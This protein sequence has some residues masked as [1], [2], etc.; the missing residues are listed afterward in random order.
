MAQPYKP[1]KLPRHE[2]PCLDPKERIKT[3]DEVALGFSEDEAVAEA[4]RC[5]SCKNSPCAKG[6]PV[7][8]DISAFLEK[9][10]ER[11]FKE[12]LE[13]I[14]EKN[15]LPGIT[16]RVCPQES[17]CECECTLGKAKGGQPLAIGAVERFVADW[18]AKNGATPAVKMEPPNGIKAGVIGSGPASLT[19]AG[20]LARAGFDV[21]VFEAFHDAGGVLLFGIPEFRMPKSILKAEVEYLESLGVKFAFDQV[22][23]KSVFVEDLFG[24]EHGFK[25]LFMGTGAGLPMFLK[26]PGENLLDVYSANEF[27][28]RV[29]LMKAY[30]FPEYDTPVKVGSTVLVVGGGN[31]ALDAAR[32]A[33]RLG[34]KQV[35]IV[36]RRTLK[37][38]PARQAEVEHAQEEGVVFKLLRAPVEIIGDAR[39][40]VTAMRFQEMTLGCLDESGRASCVPIEGAFETIPCSTVIIAIGSETN[41]ICSDATCELEVDKKKHIKVNTETQE[42]SI[43]GL[44][45]GGDAVTGSATVISAMGAAK[46]AARSMAA[47]ALKK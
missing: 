10:A 12:A 24:P 18:C 46:K 30:K 44:F 37:E 16:G 35:S 32:T 7:E 43:D 15:N 25:T 42:T 38:M 28:T 21:T 40:N 39:K 14:K 9:V 8:I 20:D 2:L 22:V 11:Q 47:F 41:T 31:V 33:L 1:S 13:I 3:F 4:Q 34:A 45:A 17:Q 5:L 19:A 26:I 36:Y 29:N 6:C 23:G 27:L